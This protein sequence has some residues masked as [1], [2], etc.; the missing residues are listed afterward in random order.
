MSLLQNFQQ[1]WKEQ[2]ASLLPKEKKVL[3]AISGGVDSVV[4]ADLLFRS[5]IDFEMAHCNFQL[6]AEDSD[7]DAVFVSALALRYAK[8]LYTATFDTNAVA[9]ERKTGIEE[10]ARNLRYDW[11][12][13]LM[14]A[15]GSLALLATAHHAND[16]LETLLINFFRGTGIAGLTGIPVKNNRIIRPLLFAGRKEITNYA[17]QQGLAWREDITNLSDD[18]TRNAFRLTILPA[19]Q[20]HF[21]NVENNLL[22]NISRF[23]DINLLYTQAVERHKKKLVEVRG[24][25]LFLPI[26]KWQ[27]TPA[28]TTLLWE[29]IRNY[30]FTSGQLAEVKKLF[31]AD[32]GSYV[33]SASHRIFRNRNH[34]VISEL[35][36]QNAGIILVEEDNTEI[37]FA[38]GKLKFSYYANDNRI[39]TD[40][41]IALLDAA[42]IKFPLI[43]RKWKAGDY[44]YPLGM[45][46]KKK[47]SRFFIDNKL[48]LTGKENI[49]VIESDKKLVWIVGMRIDERMKV[50]PSTRTIL[51]ISYIIEM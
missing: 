15:N 11:F 30:H 4:L 17:Q 13:S 47:L 7:K 50:L 10:T 14:K 45:K 43:V 26:L 12:A 3:L 16:N 39:L 41:N 33:S 35:N 9:R 34:L 20:K 36:T 2:F 46:K 19:I 44:F 38:G 23:N 25:E 24:K 49:Y 28:N 5:A 40:K 21:P 1:S 22:E 27:K 51:K 31:T 6:R 8:Q 37:K 29:V 32:N 42:R 18:Y 48:S